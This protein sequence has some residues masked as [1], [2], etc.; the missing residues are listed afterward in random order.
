MIALNEPAGQENGVPLYVHVLFELTVASRAQLEPQIDSSIALSANP[1]SPPLETQILV[2]GRPTEEQLIRC[3]EVRAV[4][5]PYAGVPS[6]TQRLL[7]SDFP[8]ISLHNLHHN[9][10]AAA[11]LAVAL[12]LDAAKSITSVDRAF[13][14]H[15]WR[16]RYDGSTMQLLHGKT[17]LLLGLGAIGTRVATICH[18]MGMNVMAVRRRPGR[19][20]PGFVRVAAPEK[21]PSLLPGADVLCVAAP[22][23]PKTE[24]LIGSKELS[25]MPNHA[26]LVNVARGAI[27]D[28]QALYDA[29][30]TKRIAAAGIDTWYAYPRTEPERVGTPP[31]RFPFWELDNVVMSPHRGGAFGSTEMEQRR[32][33]QLAEI[34]NAAATGSPLPNRVDIE[35]GY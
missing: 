13:R 7:T 1:A 31:S 9:A 5:V 6:A 8:H 10:T 24:G 28:E 32:M 16:S 35:A 23:T 20:S 21:L 11:E 25:A 26:V 3:P 18:A 19:P 15:D 33:D 12:M 22:L 29:L 34:L 14:H 17:L 4:I 27:V 2:G 30:R